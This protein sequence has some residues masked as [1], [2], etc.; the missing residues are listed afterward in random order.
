M[1]KTSGLISESKSSYEISIERNGIVGKYKIS[2][3]TIIL[4]SGSSEKTYLLVSKTITLRK[5]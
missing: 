4:N 3:T 5:K 2:A 1:Q